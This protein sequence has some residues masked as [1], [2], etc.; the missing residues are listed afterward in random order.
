MLVSCSAYPLTFKMERYAPPNCWLTFNGHQDI[1]DP[2]FLHLCTS[3]KW[4]VSFTPRP[5]YPRGKSPQYPLD[6][7]LCG[8]QSQSGR[9]GEEKILDPTGTK[10]R[11]LGRPARSQ[12][13]YR[14][15]Y[16]S[17]PLSH[18][19]SW[20]STYLVKHRDKFTFT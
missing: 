15:R 11:P 4:V 6:V 5:L 2:H 20:R 17:Y 8:P 19:P 13:L 3:W 14:L 16:P 1:I 10:T 12:S 18:T 7:R 9:R